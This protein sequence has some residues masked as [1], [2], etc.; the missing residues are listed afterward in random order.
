MF[1]R[2]PYTLTLPNGDAVRLGPRTLVMGILN[3]TPDSFADGGAHFDATRAVDAGLTMVDAGADLLDVGGESTRPGAVP[4]STEEEKRRVIPVIE[5]LARRVSVPISI[6]T[7]KA[8]VAD[9]A[10][11]AGASIVND[12]SGLVYEPA[13]GDIA[14][15][16]RMPIVLMHTRGRSADMYRDAVY[17]DPVREV[18][19]ELGQRVAFAV[20]CGIARG[21][22]VVDPGLGFAKRP[23]HS[24]A[25][26]AR[27]DALSALD[28]PILIGASRKSFLN[29]AIGDRSPDQREWA[30]ASAVAAA[31]LLGAHIV[32]VHGVAAMAD[33]VRVADRIRREVTHIE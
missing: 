25:T 26:L 20:S 8:D 3:I 10:F 22:I 28:L 27:L 30:T 33:V 17:H 9:A 16:R 1:P 7:Y 6:D 29:E 11:D 32:R 12:I 2:K 15:R 13:L 19:D 31:V 18:V 24:F 4:V 5:A 21:Q 14:A 23:E